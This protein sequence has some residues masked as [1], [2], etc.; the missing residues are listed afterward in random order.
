MLSWR[1]DLNCAP[2]LDES[3]TFSFVYRY[4][5]GDVSKQCL[6]RLS[7]A[8]T[9]VCVCMCMCVCAR[10]YVT[11]SCLKG[12]N[13]Y[14]LK[15]WGWGCALFYLILV[16]LRVKPRTLHVLASTLPLSYS[17]TQTSPSSA[18][19]GVTPMSRGGLEHGEENVI[20]NPLRSMFHAN[21]FQIVFYISN[22]LIR[23]C[24]FSVCE[25]CLDFLGYDFSIKMYRG[26]LA[27][28]WWLT[29]VIL[30]RRQ[31]SGGSQTRANS[32]ETLS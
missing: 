31:R 27:G 4:L 24:I 25:S 21:C 13:L 12:F 17:P 11:S 23:H 1:T 8:R 7:L 28:C 3:E 18:V 14:L 20:G 5:V 6:P 32:C 26:L 30:F 16:T 22:S 15:S 10:A 9:R 19:C 2:C 29:L